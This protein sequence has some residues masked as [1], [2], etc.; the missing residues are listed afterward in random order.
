[1]A[2]KDIFFKLGSFDLLP[3]SYTALDEVVKILTENPELLL[4]I[5]GH[6]DSIG[7]A[8]INKVLSARRAAAIFDYL[9]S[10]GI[11]PNRLMSIR[12]ESEKPIE[13]NTTKEG[14]SKNRR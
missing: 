13:N 2:A 4:D 5:E 1:M 7:S 3:S 14:R 12:Y 10:K 6:S 11:D 8:R 9:V